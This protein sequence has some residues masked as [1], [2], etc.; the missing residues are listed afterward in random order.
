MDIEVAVAC[1]L[2]DVFSGSRRVFIAALP[3]GRRRVWDWIAL[4]I[5]W[6]C[7]LEGASP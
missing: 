7:E 5:L 3:V 2:E 4:W 6:S 1:V